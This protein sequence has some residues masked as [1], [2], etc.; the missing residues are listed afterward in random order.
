MDLSQFLKDVLS[1]KPVIIINAG[2][3]KLTSIESLLRMLLEQ[4]K[5]RSA[6]RNATPMG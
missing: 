2:D 4:Y 3:D 6:E 1:K 5:K